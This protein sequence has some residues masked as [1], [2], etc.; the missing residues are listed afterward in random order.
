MCIASSLGPS[1][2]SSSR[3][4]VEP[5]PAPSSPVCGLVS[6]SC[7]R[8]KTSSS[9][10]GGRPRGGGGDA[11][12]WRACQQILKPQGLCRDTLAQCEPLLDAMPT[13][14]VRQEFRAYLKV[15]LETAKRLGLDDAGLPISSDAIA[16]LFGVA[17]RHG[18]GQTQEAAALTR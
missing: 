3:L 17:K 12:G 2:C 10:S 4:P 13:A 14:T 15:Q 9:A 7:P 1:S 8:G 18:V 16:S 6:M 11:Q 5:R